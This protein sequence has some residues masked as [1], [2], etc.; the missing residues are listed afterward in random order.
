[1]QSSLREGRRSIFFGRLTITAKN[2]VAE[3]ASFSIS[4]AAGADNTT[5]SLSYQKTTVANLI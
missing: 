3:K 4:K 1:M 5:L 2:P